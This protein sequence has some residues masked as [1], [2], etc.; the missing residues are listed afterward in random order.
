[1]F[2]MGLPGGQ[3]TQSSE[4]ENY[5]GFFQKGKSGMDFMDTWQ[6]QCFSF[7]LRH[8]MKRVE[9]VSKKGRYF[10]L[11]LEDNSRVEAKSV[12]VATGRYSKESR[13]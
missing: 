12:I 6:E 2:E 9:R 8:E 11:I 5:P 1:M 7:G 3:I 10:E 4:I 13:Y